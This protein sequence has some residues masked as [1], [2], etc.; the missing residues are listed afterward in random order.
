[1][2]FLTVFKDGNIYQENPELNFP[3]ALL[4]SLVAILLV[5]IVLLIIVGCVELLHLACK[6]V[7]ENKKV[8]AK[9]VAP[10]KKVEI[11]DEDMMVAALIATIDYRQEV[12]KDVKLKSIK[13]IG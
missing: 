6:N 7:K 4:V 11:T 3:Q 2:K 5:F 12:K 10:S 9:Q 1:M 13:R 8:E